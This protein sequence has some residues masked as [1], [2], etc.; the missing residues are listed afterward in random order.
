M[1]EGL[2]GRGLQASLKPW[3]G[4]LI[5][6]QFPGHLSPTRGFLAA[7]HIF[8]L[9]QGLGAFP[10]PAWNVGRMGPGG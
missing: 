9:L 10:Q 8:L 6:R 5:P 7:F 2:Q 3:C 4:L 1:S